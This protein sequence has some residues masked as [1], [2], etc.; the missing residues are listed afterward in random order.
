MFTARH[1]KERH[2]G[3][4]RNAS[5]WGML[6]MLARLKGPI[7]RIIVRIRTLVYSS[8]RLH[9]ITRGAGEGITKEPL[10]HKICVVLGETGE[11]NPK[12]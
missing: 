9:H 6:G 3:H 4:V 2:V 12:I 7:V 8:T 5:T 11:A 1:T 10:N